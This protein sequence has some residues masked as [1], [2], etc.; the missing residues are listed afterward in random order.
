[1]VDTS[2][3]FCPHTGCD[4]RGWLGLLYSDTQRLSDSEQAL[5]EALTI[6]RQLAKDNP[7][8]YLPDVA[9]T[10]N[11][12]G[13]LYRA[14]QRLSDSE[15]ALQEALTTYRQLAKDN[16]AAYL[17]DVAMTLHNLSFLELNKQNIQHAQTL[18][19]EALTLRRSLWKLHA[20]AYGNDLAQSLG[21]D[22]MLLQRQEDKGTLIC[23]RLHEM[24]TV[25]LRESLKQWA[26]ERMVTMCPSGK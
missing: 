16:P 20:A 24:A 25:A 7:V 2:M 10:L 26:Q 3:H 8:A 21:V 5:Q 1:M 13:L 15:Q 18:L 11:N 6:R 22:V 12:L 14:T 4:Y 23:D 9:G 19:D 17:P